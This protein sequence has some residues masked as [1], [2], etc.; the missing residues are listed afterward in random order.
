MHC[1]R[2]KYVLKEADPSRC[3]ACSYSG[4]AGGEMNTLSTKLDQPPRPRSVFR[5]DILAHHASSCVYIQCLHPLLRQDP[6]DSNS[7]KYFKLIVVVCVHNLSN[8]E[9]HQAV[10]SLSP[11]SQHGTES[12]KSH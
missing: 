11:V 10:W 3:T 4:E 2:L 12:R 8:P 1:Q 5:S 7:K 9:A 6:S